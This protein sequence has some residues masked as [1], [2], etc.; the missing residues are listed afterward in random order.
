MVRWRVSIKNNASTPFNIVFSKAYLNGTVLKFDYT[1]T[2]IF[3][4]IYAI[5]LLSFFS[6]FAPQTPTA[7]PRRAVNGGKRR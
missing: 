4:P 7:R 2:I 1:L 5:D 6:I 3:F